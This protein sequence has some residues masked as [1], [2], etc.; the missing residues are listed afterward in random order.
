MK[1][2]TLFILIAGVMLL[3]A[4]LWLMTNHARLSAESH[5]GA[6][7]SLSVRNNR[8]YGQAMTGYVLSL[9]GVAVM[10]NGLI[11]LRKT[12]TTGNTIILDFTEKKKQTKTG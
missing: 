4:G 1:L 10:V 6:A 7:A 3:A 8:A 5:G 12:K 11:R 9:T 2:K